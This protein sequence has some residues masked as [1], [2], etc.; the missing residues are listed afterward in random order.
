MCNEF[1][2]LMKDKFQMSSMGELTFFLG[3]QVKQKED[4]I[5]ISQDKYVAEIL[6]KF[7]YTDVKSASTPVDLEKPLVKDGD[8]DDVDVHLY[9][10]MIGSL[11]YL[12][13]SRPDIMFAVC[14]CARFQ[15]TPKTS[16]LLAVKRIFRYLKGK[17]TLG[18]WFSRNYPFELVA[19]TDSDY[20]GATQDRKSTTRG[21]QFL[22]NRLI[23]WQCK[24][25]TV[26]ATST[27]EAEYV[28][29]ASCCGQVL[30]IQNQLLDY[31][32]NFM[33]TMIHIDNNSTICI[34]ENHVQHSKTKHIE[35][36][37]HFIRDCNAKKLI[38]MVKIDTEHNVADL[39]TKGFDAGRFQYLVSR[40]SKEV[41][42]LRYLSLVVPLKK[43]GDEAVHKELGDRMERAATTASSLEAEQDSGA[44]T[45]NH[46]ANL[47]FCDKHNMVAYLQKSEGSEGFHEIIDFLTASHIHHALIENPTIYASPIE[48]FWQTAAL[49]I[50]ED[51][52]Q[53]ITAT[54]DRKLKVLVTEASIRRHLKLEDSEG[55]KTLPTIEI[56]EQ[57]ALMGPKK[58]AWEQFSSNIAT[59]IICLATNRTFNFSN[60]IFE[61]MVKNI[62]SKSKFLMYPRFIQI[63]LNKH[64]RLLFPHTRTY[65]T[66]T[67]T[68]KLFSNMKRISKGYSGV[69][70]SLFNTM[71]VQHQDEEPSHETTHESSPSRITSS[72]SL[73][74]QT[75]PSTSQPRTTFV[76][77]EPDLMPHES[78]LQSVH[79]LGR[80]EGSLTLN[81]L[82]VLC[83][84][85]S[86][87]VED[88]QN[89]LQQTKKVYSSALTKLIL[90]VKKLEKQVKTS[91][92]RRRVRLVLSED[93]DA[94]D[95]EI[96]E[97][98]SDNTDV[99][100]EEEEPTEIVED[101]GS[102]EKGEKEVSTI[103]AEHSTVIPKVSTATANL[104]YIRRSAEKRKD[105][106]KAIMR[107]D[108]S[109]QK[110]TKKQ[111]EQERLSHETAIRLQ[112]QIDE[113]ERKRI[114]RDAE[115][116]KHDPA[117]IR[118]HAQQNR[119]YSVAE[120]RKNMC[121]YL[122]NQKRATEKQ[123]EES[124]KRKKIEDDI[125]REELKAY[126]D[127]V[128]IEEFAMEIESLAT[129]ADGGS[130][131]YKIFS[132]MLD[133]FDRQDVMDLHR[134][135]EE[136]YTTSRP[137]GYDLMLW[138]DLK[139]LFQPDE[140]DEV[141]RNQHEYNLISWRLFD[142]CRIHIL[143]MDNGIA[144]HMMIEKKYPLTQEM[145]SKTLSR[146]LEVDHENEMA[147][148]LLRFIRSQVQQ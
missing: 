96:H 107:E 76:A 3:L 53:G 119:P 10:S 100:I 127:L 63:F 28:A 136:R 70:T 7:N 86:K 88:L 120:A 85:L 116:A 108:E 102:G 48:Q 90:R 34:I 145:L 132:E 131:N 74:P 93:K 112:E 18:L 65:P 83:T 97:K 64:Q 20:A 126:L 114:A 37:H 118:Y 55:L 36:R 27:T 95:A 129:K 12:T 143:L 50:I 29:A 25:Q 24:K 137:E 44:Q 117:V 60:F 1:E 134:Q 80:D 26:V 133:D 46:M 121:I 94:E 62:D 109:V 147:F 103:G 51:G 41:R 140:E 68:H 98:I 146:K 21:C 138:G 105:K 73:S 13:T 52:V 78:P 148:K 42:T 125:E 5:F 84:T 106:G 56:F 81:K 123:S 16:H 31:G 15:V 9:R 99:L 130:K 6:K 128:P 38:Q 71:L 89:D 72:P 2:K 17:P 8:A 54:I 23:S 39:L 58:T 45:S 139:I 77:E 113:E 22:G 61:A 122:K 124:T 43:V 91:K 33:N 82:T 14:A 101:Q 59:A 79:S 4:G 141:W 135:V 87:K 69:V 19:Y 92:A 142:S 49:C 11:M 32:Y 144:I 57:L 35:I 104:V 47:E 111:L 75:H 40:K 67:L 66:P 115:I 30:W 110:K